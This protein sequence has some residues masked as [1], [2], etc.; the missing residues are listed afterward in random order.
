MAPKRPSAGP[1]PPR[2]QAPAK[3][4]DKA[5]QPK[6]LSAC[7]TNPALSGRVALLSWSNLVVVSGSVYVPRRL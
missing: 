7:Y 3:W 6:D 5:Q 4:D 2:V 1:A